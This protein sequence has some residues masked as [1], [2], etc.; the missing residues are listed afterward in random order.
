MVS[1]RNV[2]GMID[3][4]VTQ[5]CSHELLQPSVTWREKSI[6]ASFIS[7]SCLVC[8]LKNHN[9]SHTNTHTYCILL[10]ANKTNY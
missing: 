10:L 6:D 2:W 4:L 7:V 1:I 8:E 5:V 3:K 9:E